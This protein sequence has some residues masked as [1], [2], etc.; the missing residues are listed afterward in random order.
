VKNKGIKLKLQET[1]GVLSKIK[2]PIQEK[3]AIT[4]ARKKRRT[5]LC[6]NK[7]RARRNMCG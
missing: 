3:G 6:K 1:S 2:K 4:R 5:P 7:G